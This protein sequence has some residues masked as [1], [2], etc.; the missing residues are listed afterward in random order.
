M[1]V[2]KEPPISNSKTLGIFSFANRACNYSLWFPSAGT[3]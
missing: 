2:S 1:E 3:K